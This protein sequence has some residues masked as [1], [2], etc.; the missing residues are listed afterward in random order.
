MKLLHILMLCTITAGLTIVPVLLEGCVSASKIDDTQGE[1]KMTDGTGTL[2]LNTTECYKKCGDHNPLMTQRFGADPWA[3]VYNDTVYVYMTGDVI[4]KDMHG[5]IKDNT[6]GQIHRISIISSRDL[7]NWEDC[8]CVDVRMPEVTSWAHNSWAP[9]AA[10]GKIDGKMQFFLYFADS[11]N[12]IG[13]LR[14]DSPSGPFTDPVGKALIDRS[15][16]NCSGVVWMFD[17]AVLVDI[18]GS[19]YLYFGGGVPKGS[20]AH[21]RTARVV[22]LGNDMASLEGDPVTIDAPYMFEDSGINRIGNTYYYSYCTNWSVPVSE[23]GKS[24]FSNGQIAW[25][26]SAN[27]SG[28]F[29]RGGIVL[30]NPGVFFGDWGNNHH[31]IFQFHGQ[32]YIIYHA[33]LLSA[34]MDIR[35]GYRS[36]NID[37]LTV[38]GDGVLQQVSGTRKGVSQVISVNPYEKHSASLMSSMAGISTTGA[39]SE[40]LHY[41]CGS[42]AVTGINAGDWIFVEGVDFGSTGAASFTASV[43]KQQKTSGGILICA[44]S[45]DSPVGYLDVTAGSVQNSWQQETIQLKSRLTGKHNLLFV[46]SGSEFDWCDWEFLQ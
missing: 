11:A 40:S 10:A 17:P 2:K 13:V 38:T 41:G 20:E 22:K 30:P 26:T 28:P 3:L 18:D 24:G 46:F 44:D 4:E 25:M 43:K 6:Y 7:V 31:C 27:P 33:Q 19:A 39:G 36:S 32:W 8:G 1:N 9:A 16:S 34:A 21:P 23:A 12:G 5:G 45:F 14:S 42:M 29:S 37:R 15:A 35:H